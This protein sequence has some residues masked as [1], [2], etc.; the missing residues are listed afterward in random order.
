MT[1]DGT[2]LTLSDPEDKWRCLGG[3][4][5]LIERDCLESGERM[6]CP[7]IPKGKWSTLVRYRVISYLLLCNKLPP[8]LAA[9]DNKHL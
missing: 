1:G 9:S 2:L 6:W 5:R 7:Q 3:P 4:F 8:N